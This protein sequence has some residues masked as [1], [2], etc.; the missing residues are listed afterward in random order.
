MKMTFVGKEVTEKLVNND[1]R[2]LT[3]KQTKN[4]RL[5]NQVKQMID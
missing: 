5:F 3:N 2:T 1:E 4:D